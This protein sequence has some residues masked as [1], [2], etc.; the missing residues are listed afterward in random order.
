MSP[1]ENTIERRSTDS[2]VTIPWE[3]SFRDL[4]RNAEL[5]TASQ[6]V[7]GCGWPQHMLVPKGTAAG[8]LY[9]LYVLVTNGTL[10]QVARRNRQSEANRQSCRDSISYCG[11][12]DELYPD[13]RPMGYPFDRYIRLVNSRPL[14]NLDA[15]VQDVPNS[16][17]TQVRIG[18]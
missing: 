10:D 4:E 5:P 14:A 17:T 11:I 6:A 1:G 18:Y 3:Q 16:R 12:L 13:A 9:D 2:S 8:M 15:F 7:C